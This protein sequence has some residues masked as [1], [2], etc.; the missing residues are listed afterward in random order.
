M[1]NCDNT[2]QKSIEKEINQKIATSQKS[3]KKNMEDLF[4]TNCV[5]DAWKGLKIVCI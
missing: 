2:Q 4:K 5:K 1:R 3:H